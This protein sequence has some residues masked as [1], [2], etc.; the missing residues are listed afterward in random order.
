MSEINMPQLAQI[1]GLSCI[2]NQ[3]LK[4]MD[5][6]K[7]DISPIYA[8]SGI[9]L[10]TLCKYFIEN[11]KSYENFEE[12]PRIQD[13]LKKMGLISLKLMQSDSN[14]LK[15]IITNT[16]NKEYVFAKIAPEYVKNNLFA[17]G[18]RNDHFV[19][20]LKKDDG[21]KLI[22]DIPAITKNIS[23]DE[24]LKIY[25][26]E[27]FELKINRD[28]SDSEKQYLWNNRLFKPE[29]EN[30]YHFVINYHGNIPGL[31]EKIRDMAVVYKISRQRMKVYYSAYF[32]TSFMGGY[33][34]AI[35]KSLAGLGYMCVRKNFEMKKVFGILN[36]L[37]DVHND[38]I[39]QIKKLISLSP[40]AGKVYVM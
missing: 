12:I 32:N 3:V 34:Q 28:I 20:I 7:I 21:Y 30:E 9:P 1:Y 15:S 27:Y 25:A 8:N 10:K 2:E 26:G 11:K 29:E 4:I 5:N 39:K 33:L 18:W 24:L 16:G 14:K 36:D 13:T 40:L 37:C 31:A 17:R 6:E 35:E 22:N 23:N 38:S 19:L